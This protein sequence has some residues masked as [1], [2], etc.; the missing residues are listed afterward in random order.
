YQILSSVV[1]KRADVSYDPDGMYIPQEWYCTDRRHK[2]ETGWMPFHLLQEDSGVQIL[3]ASNENTEQKKNDRKTLQQRIRGV[4]DNRYVRA[5]LETTV[6]FV[7]MEIILSLTASVSDLKYVDIRLMFV[8][9][10]CSIHGMG[11]GILSIILACFS[12]IMHLY[13]AH[14]DISYFLYQVD[15]WIPFACYI[16]LGGFVG[17]MFDVLRDEKES[18]QGKNQLL[19]EKYDF[20]KNIH[21]ETLQIKKQLQKQITISSNSFGH[22]YEVASRLDTL[23]PEEILLR[24]IDIVE[25]VMQC[26]QA[27]IFLLGRDYARR[28][29]CSPSLKSQISSSLKMSDYPELIR[30]LND[31]E[32]FVN[33]QMLAEYPDM[34]SPIYAQGKLY[35]FAA[36]YDLPTENFTVFYQNLMRILTSLIER[37]LSKALQYEEARRKEMYIEGTELLKKEAFEQQWEILTQ[38]DETGYTDCMKYHV[39]SSKPISDEQ[40]GEKLLGLIRNNDFMG[41]DED[42]SYAVILMNMNPAFYDHIRERFSAKDLSIEVVE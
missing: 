33:T 39:K 25:D 2:D 22:V 32:V 15:S 23:N 18:L 34:A 26:H 4:S 28:R 38:M 9:V 7:L 5:A 19:S 24:V 10:C 27:S 30:A 37:N 35:G 42:G 29:A 11:S 12:Y 40:M 31:G 41:I 6:L 14:V 3:K 20:L 8:A 1:G 13:M 17:Y 36:I 21:Q 16:A